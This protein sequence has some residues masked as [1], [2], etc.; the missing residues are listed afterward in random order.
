MVSKDQIYNS[1]LESINSNKR[2]AN[3]SDSSDKIQ[4]LIVR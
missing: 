1:N 3:V 4:A 2:K